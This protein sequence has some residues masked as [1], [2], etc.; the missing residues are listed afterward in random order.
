MFSP[1][2][3]VLSRPGALAFSSSALLAR[4]PSSTVGLGL[5]LL[6]EHVSGSYGLAGTV[7]A[8]YV[9]AQAAV[10]VLHGRLLDRLGQGRVLT[11]AV[12]G[13]A[14]ALTLLVL[15][16]AAERSTWL[17][18]T[19]AALAGAF[20]PQ[21]GACVRARWA[22]VL[23]SGR[24]LQTAFALESVLDE[25]VF[26]VGP[27]LVTTL[28]IGW[29]PAAALAAAAGAGVV[30][31]L[32]LASRTDTAPPARPRIPGAGRRPALGW[33]TLAPLA[34]VSLS[35]GSLFGVAEVATLAF[36][37]E[38]G[39]TGLAGPLLAIWA[40]GSLCGGLASGAVRWRLGSRARV[41]VGMGLL[42][43]AMVPLVFIDSPLLLGL[44]LLCGGCVIA[45]TLIAALTLVQLS[46]PA[47]RLTEGMAVVQTGLVAG[48][49]PG[50]A[51]GGALIDAHGAAAGFAVAV[52]AGLLGTLAAQLLRGRAS[53]TPEP[54]S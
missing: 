38:R 28:A 4:L 30:G 39:A 7:A 42:T 20:L 32:L 52:A 6:V 44:T 36:A 8:V 9:L 13:F 40:A 23:G 27:V 41:R 5:I 26:V 34:V 1:Y 10:A 51:I 50:A 18:W 19:A 47:E 54:T 43:L 21:I 31:T 35:L 46:V 24:E 14:A 29:H 11:V 15:A 53:A 3:R 33:S 45:P 17:V 25:L 16:V 49:A 37:D 12:V 22:Y 2:R 48:V